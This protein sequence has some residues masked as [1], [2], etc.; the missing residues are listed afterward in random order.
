MSGLDFTF[1][2]VNFGA[3]KGTVVAANKET[4]RKTLGQ[5]ALGQMKIA[6]V[7][8]VPPQETLGAVLRSMQSNSIGSILVQDEAGLKGVFTERDFMTRILGKNPDL[9]AA[10]ERYMTPK[11]FFLTPKDSLL[12]AID[13]MV[14]H[15]IRHVPVV[16]GPGQPL[17][18]IS[19]R[20]AIDACCELP[21]EMFS[22]KIRNL[23]PQSPITAKLS[24][25]L[26]RVIAL[27]A[28]KS[29]GCVVVV[30]GAAVK[31]IFT[32][33]D[34]LLQ[35]ARSTI[36]LKAAKVTDYMTPD[37]EPIAPGDSVQAALLKMSEG[38][39]RH[40]TVMENG[41]LVGVISVRDILYHLV[42]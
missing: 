20:D 39:F 2:R 3:R 42:G 29:L 14:K 27:M 28:E 5:M 24:D 33:R 38:G 21:S 13:L 4:L 32:E 11:P 23:P 17:K 8:K 6:T 26:E 22:E 7:L 37:P 18:V 16:S 36:D 25:P 9:N 15:D 35:L 19:V 31:G 1:S 41:R 34:V 30:D 12:A 40:L 10:I